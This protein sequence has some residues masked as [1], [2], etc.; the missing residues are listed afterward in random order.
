MMRHSSKLLL[1]FA[2]LLLLGGLEIIDYQ[3][4]MTSYQQA[5]KD[6]KRLQKQ[7]GLPDL[8]ITGAASY[9]RHYSISDMTTAFQ[10][11]PA[12][13]DHFPAGFVYSTPDYSNMPTSIFYGKRDRLRINH[14]NRQS[15]E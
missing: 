2:V 10:D 6:R 12:S 1:V 15:D 11:Y 9:L 7:I 14:K 5:L 13:L 3:F 4:R 8:A